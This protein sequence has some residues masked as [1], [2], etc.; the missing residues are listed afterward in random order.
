MAH[1]TQ[2]QRDI[3]NLQAYQARHHE[4][5]IAKWQ[6]QFSK[7]IMALSPKEVR[8]IKRKRQRQLAQQSRH[9]RNKTNFNFFI[10]K[11]KAKS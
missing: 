9:K 2:Q 3:N 4:R 6:K 8:R 11:D 10:L 1:I 5:Q 7:D